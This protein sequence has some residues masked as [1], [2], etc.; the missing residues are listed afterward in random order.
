M[1][2]LKQPSRPRPTVSGANE[3]EAFLQQAQQFAARFAGVEGVVGVLLTGGAARGYADHFSELDLAIYL[4]RPLF[5]DWTRRGNAP[6]PEG[7]SLVESWHV[8]LDYFCYEDE[9]EGEWEHSKRWDRSYAVVLVDPQ[10]LLREM[11][12]RK[13]VLDVDEKRRLTSRYLVLYGEYFCDVVARSWVDRGDLL[14]AHDCLNVTLD[15]L[16]K[17]VFLANDELVPFEKWV[18]NLSYTLDWTPGDWRRKVEEA[19]LV[20]EISGA[21]VERR[22][23]L[24]SGLLVECRRRLI[25]EQA[26]DLGAVEARKLAVLRAIRESGAMPVEE[27][28][29]RLGVRALIQSP[30]FHLLR[31]EARDGE[32]WVVLDEER[33]RD[34]A[35]RDFE[36]FLD[37][38]RALLRALVAQEAT[39]SGSGEPGSQ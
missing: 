15:I 26:G 22:R 23:A 24:I 18:L 34:R 4:S 14:A 28:D 35:A 13:A 37:W 11:L 36:G 25:G 32:E 12:D 20:R 5:E 7:D 6:L 39:R 27:F 8:D 9:L 2:D 19:L 10:G 21:E 17:A 3:S 16:I 1:A 38:N 33:L 31:R 29:R 30:L